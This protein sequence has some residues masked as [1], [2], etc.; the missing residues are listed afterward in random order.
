MRVGLLRALFKFDFSILL[1][2]SPSLSKSM[3]TDSHYLQL[4]YHSSL[5]FII[6]NMI[7]CPRRMYKTS[8]PIR[9]VFLYSNFCLNPYIIQPK[10]CF[11]EFLNWPFLPR[12]LQCVSFIHLQVPCHSLQSVLNDFFRPSFACMDSFLGYAQFIEDILHLSQC[13]LVFLLESFL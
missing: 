3:K 6:N 5:V 12:S 4:I 9:L 1:K 7:I 11:S 10:P 8:L 13:I 2:D